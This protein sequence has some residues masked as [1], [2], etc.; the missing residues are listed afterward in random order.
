MKLD[1]GKVALSLG[2]FFGLVHLV[3]ALLVLLI[4]SILQ[5]FLN[6]IYGVHFLNNPF[7]VTGFNL[8]KAISLVLYTFV[9]GYIFGWVFAEV[10]NWA[11]KRK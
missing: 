2:I 7:F 4:P 1:K 8:V 6:W 9:V 11:Q 10:W 5:T 3:W